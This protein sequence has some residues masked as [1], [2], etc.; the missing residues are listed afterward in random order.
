VSLGPK[1]TV[2]LCMIVRNESGQLAECLGPVASL[3]DEIVIVDTGSHDAT[4][5]IAARFTPHVFDFPWCDDFSAARNESLRR[6]HGEWVFWLD[7][8]D[9][10][11]PEN[12]DRLRR[13]LSNLA[14]QPRAYMM[15]TA[16]VSQFACEGSHLITHP[17][18]FRRHPE[19]R[20]QGRVHEQL[21]PDL[22]SLGYDV[23]WS[24]VQIEH[25][26]Y[27]DRTIEQRKLHRDV[28]LL[29]M[30]YAVDPDDASTLVHLGLAY[31]RLGKWDEA[32][33]Y[34]ERVLAA[35]QSPG[36]YLR[37][38]YAALASISLREG[39]VRAALQTLHRA[40]AIFPTDE[41]L[42]YLK[43]DCLYELDEYA[44]AKDTLIQI[45]TSSELLHYHGGVPGEIKQKLAPRKLADVLR[46]EGQYVA[47]ETL[48]RSV[49][50]C[51]P[52]DTISW[53]A[54][55]RVYLDTRQ[56]V[57]LLSVVERLR[58]CPQGDVFAAL[59]LATWHLAERQLDSAG[60]LI[61]QLIS[62]A[63][64]MPLPRVLRAEWLALSGASLTARIQACRDILRVQ[65]GNLDAQ[66]VLRN[67]KAAQQQPAAASSN[68]W[69]TSVVLGV[70]VPNGLSLASP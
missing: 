50:D 52:S 29:R 36:E 43:A 12:V 23:A 27:Q 6:S 9:R 69:C 16:C 61:E 42:L 31:F 63:P 22:P 24:D 48:L 18:L 21:R 34:L 41:Y 67:L 4:K 5:Q 13:L 57:S 15:D 32:R 37:Q 30:D 14:H 65:P 46:L 25:V 60:E 35:A 2:S 20:W 40:E 17:R 58:C 7:A 55:G 56:R 44:A 33:L 70:G 28:R 53:H 11:T 54:L 66:R 64:Q 45:L 49:A 39:N 26:G 3:F 51:F 1:A 8:D 47:A 19:L 38:V 59:L 62:Q 10:L 68:D